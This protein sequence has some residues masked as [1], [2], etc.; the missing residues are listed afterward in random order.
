MHGL[1]TGGW[2]STRLLYPSPPQESEEQ[3][4]AHCDDKPAVEFLFRIHVI[5]NAGVHRTPLRRGL[6]VRC[7]ALFGKSISTC[8]NAPV[9]NLC[10][11]LDISV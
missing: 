9:R 10:R 3:K 7:D 8:C 6:A 1:M 5:A 4:E 2:P 11:T